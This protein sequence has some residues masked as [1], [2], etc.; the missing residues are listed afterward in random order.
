M[1]AKA[2]NEVHSNKVLRNKLIENGFKKL[3]ELKKNNFTSVIPT[4]FKNYFKIQKT[5]KLN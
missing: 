3:I 1:L 5:W 2:I 4:I